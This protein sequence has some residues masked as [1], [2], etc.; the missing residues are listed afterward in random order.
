[1][2]IRLAKCYDVRI[3]DKPL[4]KL[5]RY[6]GDAKKAQ[7]VHQ[8]TQQIISEALETI[9]PEVMFPHLQLYS[10]NALIRSS[11][12]AVRGAILMSYEFY[13]D[14]KDNFNRAHQICPDA[15]LHKMWLGVFARRTMKYQEAVS[16]F[17]EIP[18]EDNFYIDAKWAM[19]LTN[20]MQKTAPKVSRKLR[21]ELANEYNI[22]LQLALDFA[23]GKTNGLVPLLSNMATDIQSYLGWD[24]PKV[25]A[26]LFRGEQLMRDEW[27]KKSPKTSE[28][29]TNFYRET[30]NY[31]FDLAWWH[32][33]YGR[34]KLTMAA[35][36]ACKRNN[37][38]KILEFGCGTGQ[39]GILF[40]EEGFDVTLADLP[41][42]TFDYAKWRVKKG[43]L[44]LKFADSDQ[45]TEKYDAILCFDVLEHLWE[46][47]KMVEYLYQHLS[48][49]GILLVTTH[50]GHD[51]TH[52]MHLER[53]DKYAGGQFFK[54]MS[55]AGLH[56]EPLTR[57]PFV[58]HVQPLHF[59]E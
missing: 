42:K 52:P 32:R 30:E 6:S 27:N 57:N 9:P 49:N 23:D 14:A 56:L 17:S 35:I 19:T 44:D 25:L 45:L 50:F 31:V 39:D 41:S 48:N 43:E 8:E 3:V 51:E 46:P 29:I 58:F 21:N 38:N 11:A 12:Y 4:V 26:A 47:Q 13:E 18:E 16:H 40:A 7:S 34:R 28:E 33:D 53:N 36:E 22:L 24:M 54:M 55:V 5:K 20:Q 15:S 37:S 10:E 59:Q 1:M 2:L